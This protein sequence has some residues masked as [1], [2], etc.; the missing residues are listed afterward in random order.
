MISCSFICRLDGYYFYKWFLDDQLFLTNTKADVGAANYPFNLAE[1]FIFNV[2][3]G[4]HWPGSPDG[5]TTFPQRM[6][7]D[8]VR[9]FQ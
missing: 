7:V 3:V 5:T 4:G 6:F 9:V 1:F 8:Y 2:A